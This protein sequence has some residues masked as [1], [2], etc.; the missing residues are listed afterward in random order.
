MVTANSE[1]QT[2]ESSNILSSRE[3][4][5]L[6]TGIGLMPGRDGILSRVLH[7]RKIFSNKQT[8]LMSIK[9]MH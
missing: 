7:E 4:K 6:I 5:T 1:T 8:T 3:R 2:T 9:G